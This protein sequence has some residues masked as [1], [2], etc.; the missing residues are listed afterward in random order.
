MASLT[1]PEAIS[2]FQLLTLREAVKMEG[3]GMKHSSGRSATAHA[4]RLLG[5]PRGAKRETVLAELNKRLEVRH[6]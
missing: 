6:A 4:R 5:L 1:T 2:R 3:L